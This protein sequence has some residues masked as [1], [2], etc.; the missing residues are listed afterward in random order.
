[1]SQKVITKNP[2]RQERGKKS[3]ETYMKRL[4][5]KI[6]EDNSCLTL[7]LQIGLYLLPLPLQVT[8]CFLSLSLQITLRLLHIPLLIPMSVTLVC[9]LSLPLV[10]PYFLHTERRQEKS[11][12]NNLLNQNGVICFRKKCNK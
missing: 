9:F 8:L 10:F 12:I 5:E 6:L 2:R 1:M 4:K 7:P 3:H 11:S